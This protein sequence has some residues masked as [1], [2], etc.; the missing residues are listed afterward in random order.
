MLPASSGSNNACARSPTTACAPQGQA[1]ARRIAY[2]SAHGVAA[3][4]RLG[5][6][7]HADAASGADYRYVQGLAGI[8]LGSWLWCPILGLGRVVGLRPVQPPRHRG[9]CRRK[10]SHHPRQRARRAVREGSQRQ[11]RHDAAAVLRQADGCVSR[12]QRSASSISAP[13]IARNAQPADLR[14]RA[15]LSLL[16]SVCGI[17]RKVMTC[18]MA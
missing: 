4:K 18:A 7:E 3:A 1:A 14:L 17:L 16:G 15:C 6:H 11:R 9:G 12:S 5:N 8:G 13:N 2:Q 10:D